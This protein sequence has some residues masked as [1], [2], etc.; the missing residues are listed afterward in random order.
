MKTTSQTLAHLAIVGI[1]AGFL[2]NAAFA[3]DKDAMP[4]KDKDTSMSS[5][6]PG[7]SAMA[8]PHEHGCKGMNECKGMGGCKM[9]KKDLKKAAK[10]MEMGMDKAGK[11]HDCKGKN[12]CKGL[13]GCKG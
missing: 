12:E 13:G 3:G 5:P 4:A 2:S 1:A 10:K 6:A 11:A 9:S 7:D 8:T